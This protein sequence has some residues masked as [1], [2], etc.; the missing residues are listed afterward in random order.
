M[1][2]LVFAVFINIFIT[3]KYSLSFTFKPD[4]NSYSLTHGQILINLTIN[5]NQG[6]E[7]TIFIA[8]KD[9]QNVEI[10]LEKHK[11]SKSQTT[12]TSYDFF[13]EYVIDYEKS[14][15][16]KYLIKYDCNDSSKSKG[17]KEWNILMPARRMQYVPKYYRVVQG[18]SI[19]L[20]CD[21]DSN[22]SSSLTWTMDNNTITSSSKQTIVN[23]P[24]KTSLTISDIEES[25]ENT[26]MCRAENNECV[27]TFPYI[28]KVRAKLAIL[29]PILGIIFQIIILLIFILSSVYGHKF[30]PKSKI[31]IKN[32]KYR[33]ITETKL[34]PNV[35]RVSDST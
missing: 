7:C 32:K 8:Y 22:P 26:Y 3:G 18:S 30:K 28:I 17:N 2:L 31:N 9:L 12:I 33:K 15:S 6:M 35:Y 1:K 16:G 13:Q 19:T 21:I 25:D 4:V 29:W 23:E 34:L 10:E 11:H 27:I 14:K 20:V 24:Q 5:H